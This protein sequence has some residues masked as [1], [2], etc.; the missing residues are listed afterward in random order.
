M[1]CFICSCIPI[2]NTIFKIVTLFSP[3]VNRHDGF[4]EVPAMEDYKIKAE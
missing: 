2:R 3:F 1:N 4:K